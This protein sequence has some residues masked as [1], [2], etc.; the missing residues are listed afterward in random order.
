MSALRSYAMDNGGWYPRG[1]VTPLASLQKLHPNYLS[2]LPLAG[3]SGDRGETVKR[4][5]C[6]QPLDEAVS[7]WIY[8]PGFRENDDPSVAILWERV[9][10][11]TFNGGRSPGT[12]CVGFANGTWRQI[13]V[14]AWTDFV[15]EQENLHRRILADRKAKGS[16]N[17]KPERAD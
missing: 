13:P 17:L 4:L 14:S 16:E 8:H 3:I 11:L 6:G 7:S 10:G 12:R 5:Q 1:G 15:A 9:V 2:G